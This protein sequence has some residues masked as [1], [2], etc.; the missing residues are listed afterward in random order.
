MKKVFAILLVLL[1]S[2]TM[3]ACTKEVTVTGITVMP[4]TKV[5]YTVGDVFSAAGM[6]VK[7]QYS[8]ETEE[9]FAAADYTVSGFSSTTAGLV[10]VT[11][12]AEGL[13]ATFGIAV[14][15]P[16]APEVAQSIQV[17]NAPTQQFYLVAETFSTAGLEV[18]VT[19][20]TG[21]KAVLAEADYDLSGFIQGIIGKYTVIVNYNSLT[22]TFPAEV[23]NVNVQGVTST[24]IL[25]G[26]TATTEYIYTSFIGLPFNAGINAAFEVINEAGGINGRTIRL[27]NYDDSFNGTIGLTNTRKLIDEDN[28]FALVGHFGTPTVSATL[29]LIHETGIPMVYAATGAMGLYKE[30][31]PLDPVMP[32]QPIYLTDGRM[33]TARAIHESVYGATSD[34][35]LPADAK[36]GVLYTN[37][38]AGIGMKAGI[39]IE[40]KNNGKTADMIYKSFSK[41]D[42]TSLTAAIGD[43]RTAGVQAILIATNQGPTKTALG[44]LNQQGMTIPVFTSYVNADP[45]AVDVD[46]VYGFDVYTNAWL[47]VTAAENAT[48]VAAFVAA[49]NTFD[50]L[51]Q[52][53]K[54]AYSINAFAM[55]GYV[56]AQTFIQGIQRVGTDELTWES[57]IK[58]MESAPVNIPMGGFIDFSNGQRVGIIDMSLLKYA[59]VNGDNPLTTAVETKY[60]TFNLAF[61]IENIEDVNN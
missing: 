49:I 43:L 13:T 37:D 18:Q 57:Y 31:S 26:N 54:D 44:V 47:D 45:S 38:D 46:A 8:D 15:D 3:I 58:A 55:A 34:Q 7:V 35:A 32:V 2:F 21:R 11:V 14:F 9:T 24:E 42:V 50:E 17:L 10:T 52:A 53:D 60:A 39:T 1:A 28:V 51:T 41:D 36:I 59:I 29:P 22:A 33:F 20:S 23:R 19:Y 27:I 56:A 40:A 25:V 16:D 30:N 12:T 61:P 4:P 6:V 48:D 5:E